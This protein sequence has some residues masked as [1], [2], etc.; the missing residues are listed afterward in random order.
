M[1]HPRLVWSI[2]VALATLLVAGGAFALYGSPACAC[3]TTNDWLQPTL[4]DLDTQIQQYAAEHQG[5]YPTYAEIA[6]WPQPVAGFAGPMPLTSNVSLTTGRFGFALTAADIKTIGYAVSADR[7]SYLLVCA[8]E[9][10]H[11]VTF[12][13]PVR[14]L[15]PH[16]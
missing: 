6:Q 1:K 5:L 11:W 7:R 10:D 12:L 16:Q 14:L 15:H 13:G 3:I 4:D 8:G 2:G 9:R